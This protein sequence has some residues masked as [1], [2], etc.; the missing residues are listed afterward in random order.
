MSDNLISE[1]IIP[2]N[3][4][5]FEFKDD[6]AFR[7]KKAYINI[8]SLNNQKLVLSKESYSTGFNYKQFIPSDF[9]MNGIEVGYD[10]AWGTNWP[11][12]HKF[13]H[14]ENFEEHTLNLNSLYIRLSGTCRNCHVEI[15]DGSGNK[16]DLYP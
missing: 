1:K 16:F 3:G 9:C 13:R 2:F 15:E 4:C 11:I 6:G 12:K 14:G 8:Y 7:C 5:D 10:I